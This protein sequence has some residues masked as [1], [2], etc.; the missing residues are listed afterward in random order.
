MSKNINGKIK[1]CKLDFANNTFI[2]NYKFAAA[3]NDI[4]SPEF[5][6]YKKV[7]KE[8]PQLELVVKAGRTYTKPRKNKRF[9]YA[10]MEKYISTFDN[11]DELLQRFILVI[12]YYLFAVF[13]F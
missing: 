9:S 6:Y 12:K 5:K 8:C 11:A 1:G 7:M 2:V 4:S 3:M 10:N 13:A